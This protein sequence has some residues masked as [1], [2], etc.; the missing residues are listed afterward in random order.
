MRTPIALLFLSVASAP[1]WAEPATPEGAA[2]IE[3]ALRSVLGSTE[4]VVTVTPEG[5][6]YALSVD[7]TPLAALVPAPGMTFE[8]TPFEMTLSD[9]GDGRWQVDSPEGPFSL[10]LAVPGAVDMAL[11]VEASSWT[12]VW[13]EALSAFETSSG[14][15]GALTLSQTTMAPEQPAQTVTYRVAETIFSSSAQAGAAGGVDG[16]SRY[17]MSGLH[18]TFTMPAPDGAS[19]EITLDVASYVTDGTM[20]GMR[21][22]EL[23]D[24]V[25]WAVGHGSAEAMAGDEDGLKAAIRAA[26]P[27]WDS[28]D[29]IS[30]GD[31]VSVVTPFGTGGAET[32]LVEASLAGAVAD[33]RFRERLSVSGLQ[34]PEAILPAWAVPLLPRDVNLDFSISDFDASAPALLMLDTLSFAAPPAPGFGQTLAMAAIPDGS[35]TISLAGTGVTGEGFDVTLDGALQVGPMSMPVGSGTLVVTGIDTILGHLN[36]APQ[37]ISGGAVPGLMMA[38]GLARADGDR[39]VWDFE[40]TADGKMLVNGNDLSTL[41]Q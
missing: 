35:V 5:E 18:E 17:E 12:G 33:G 4:G 30:T 8:A 34:L 14:R 41:A 36:A 25:A 38:R 40:A 32:V 31:G 22:A 9:L 11:S 19:A 13:S 26:L 21:T 23:L 6:T 3:A 29:A 39:L 7:A 10:K 15:F 27:L 28:I 1:A 37:E 24:L 16:Q 2:G 20:T